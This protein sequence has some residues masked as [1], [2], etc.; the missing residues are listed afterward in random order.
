VSVFL[1]TVVGV[2]VCEWNSILLI[3]GVGYAIAA[4]AV[5]QKCAKTRNIMTTG[6]VTGLHSH[7]RANTRTMGTDW[8][9]RAASEASG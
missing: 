3:D 2:G 7:K 5:M 8:Y 1:S 9:V 4:M 6:I